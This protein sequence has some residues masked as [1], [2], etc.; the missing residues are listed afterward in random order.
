[1]RSMALVLCVV[2]AGC[3]NNPTMPTGSAYAGEWSG[4]TLHGSPIAFSLSA[5]DKVTTIVVGHSFGGCSG[6]QTFSNLSL[7]IVPDV[8][9]IPGPCTP[10]VASFRRFG[11]ASG[12]PAGPATSINGVFLS[13]S[14]AEGSVNFRDYPGCGSAIGVPRTATRR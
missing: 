12:G 1:M 9:C 5:D 14:R 10:G 7:D 6:S 4:T 2:A 8:I 13:S 3:Q 11:Y